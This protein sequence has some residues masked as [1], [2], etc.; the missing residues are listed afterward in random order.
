MKLKDYEYEY[1]LY[2]IEEKLKMLLPSQNKNGY[3][4]HWDEGLGIRLDSCKEEYCFSNFKLMAE[5][6]RLVNLNYV[7]KETFYSIYNKVLN[8]GEIYGFR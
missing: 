6:M 4:F 2:V 1:L 3:Y 5:I 8:K 7:S